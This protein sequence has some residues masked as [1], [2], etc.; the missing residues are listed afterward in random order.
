MWF[1]QSPKYL[2]ANV[3]LLNLSSKRLAE[4]SLSNE[5]IIGHCLKPFVGPLL[6][7]ERPGVQTLHHR[8]RVNPPS[9]GHPLW[10]VSSRH[11]MLQSNDPPRTRRVSFQAREPAH[12]LYLSASAQVH[13][14]LLPAWPSLICPVYHLLFCE[15]V[16]HTVP[17]IHRVSE[18]SHS[19]LSQKRSVHCLPLQK[20]SAPCIKGIYFHAP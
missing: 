14:H 15:S 5:N 20:F 19:L 17:T 9:S 11:P 6:L 1:E 13:T 18:A 4:A 8:T 16:T 7:R 3:P 2:T 10:P 12:I